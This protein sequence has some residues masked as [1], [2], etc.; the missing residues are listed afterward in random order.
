MANTLVKSAVVTFT[1]VVS[2]L[3]SIIP[4]NAL[5]NLPYLQ[6]DQFSAISDVNIR[7]APCSSTVVGGARKGTTAYY[8]GNVSETKTC[9]GR[10]SK[11]RNVVF[12]GPNPDGGNE[13]VE[14][15]VADYLLDNVAEVQKA[16]KTS[17][18]VRVNVNS[19][20]LAL[21]KNSLNGAVLK[22]L[23]NKSEVYV[24]GYAA[25]VTI[26]GVKRYPTRV[27]FID[28]NGI[29]TLGWVDATYLVAYSVYD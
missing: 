11:W 15:W 23:P 2:S 25:P 14:G 3:V 28:S 29:K 24:N 12:V 21:R 4:A 19:G 10:T 1:A 13:S 22:R 9:F 8:V 7:L 16:D 20:T 5:P 17:A 26:G 27:L 6:E 18:Y